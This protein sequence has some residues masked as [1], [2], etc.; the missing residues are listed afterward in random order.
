[1]SLLCLRLQESEG[2]T[3]VTPGTHTAEHARLQNQQLLC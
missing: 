1:M 2:V 3:L